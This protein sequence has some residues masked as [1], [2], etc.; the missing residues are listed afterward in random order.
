[1]KV[2]FWFS[3]EIIFRCVLTAKDSQQT[4]SFTVDPAEEPNRILEVEVCSGDFILTLIPTMTDYKSALDDIETSDWKGKL[5]KKLGDVMLSA[6]DKML[7]RVGC[8]YHVTG[9]RDGDTVFIG[10]QGYILGNLAGM[11]L[12]ELI[13]VIY[14][15]LEPSCNGQRFELTDAFETNRKDFIKYIKKYCLIDFGWQLIITYPIQVGRAKRLT[16][17]KKISKTLK[18]FNRL[19]DADREKFLR[20]QEKMMSR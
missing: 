17:S 3:D 19:N 16:T 4:Q 1:M 10:Q 15:F 11:E 8:K 13:P 20:K 6:F 5:A 2:N 9:I 14:M 18:K 7:L 12:L